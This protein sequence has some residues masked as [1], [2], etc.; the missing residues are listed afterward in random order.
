MNKNNPIKAFQDTLDATL[1]KQAKNIKKKSKNASIHQDYIYKI[2]LVVFGLILSYELIL[3]LISHYT[4]ERATIVFAIVTTVFFFL[5]AR[6][7]KSFAGKLLNFLKLHKQNFV[8]GF[9]VLYFLI[10]LSS[11]I[12]KVSDIFIYATYAMIVVYAFFKTL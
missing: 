1:Q 8:Y 12:F 6:S 11:F 10:F 5:K 3:Y 7:K 9:F 4:L 2:I